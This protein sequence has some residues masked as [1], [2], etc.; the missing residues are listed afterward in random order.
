LQI[1]ACQEQIRAHEDEV[2][3]KISEMERAHKEQ[4]A[5]IGERVKQTVVKKDQVIEQLRGKLAQCGL[6]PGQAPQ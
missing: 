3:K 5:A 1:S 6:L 4:I 2:Q